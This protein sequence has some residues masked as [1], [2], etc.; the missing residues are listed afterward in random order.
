MRYAYLHGFASS[1][2]SSKGVFLAERLAPRGIHLERPDLNAPSFADLTVTDALAAFRSLGPGPWRLVGSSLGGYLAA[3][4]AELYPSE[5]DRLVLLCPGFGLP[6]RWQQ[7]MGPEAFAR[8][9]RD[10]RATFPDGTGQPVPVHFGF[11]T[12]ARRH[13]DAPEVRCPTLILHGVADAVVPIAS[14]RAYAAAR[15]HVT[16]VELDGDHRLMGCLDRVEAEVLRFLVD[17]PAPR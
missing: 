16:L 3:R 6:A 14:S 2:R 5:V 13:P 17:T 11:V 12:D 4:F 15:P 7:L 1:A 8:W 9:E 10:G